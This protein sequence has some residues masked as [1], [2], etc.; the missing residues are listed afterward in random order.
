MEALYSDT[1]IYRGYDGAG[2][3]EEYTYGYL[4][5]FDLSIPLNLPVTDWVISFE[6]GEHV[7]SSSEGMMIRNLHKHNCKGILLSWGIEGQGG[8]DHINLHNNNH[9][10]EIFKELGYVHDAEKTTELRDTIPNALVNGEW[11]RHTLMVLRREK[12]VC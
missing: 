6:V 8:D 2:D 1:L 7:P 9:L 3:V 10:I 4:K 12:A 11:F 5:F